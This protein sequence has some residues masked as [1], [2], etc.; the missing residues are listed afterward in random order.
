VSGAGLEA[1]FIDSAGVRLI[2]GLYLAGG[3]RP[4]PA[5]LLLHG[6]PGH[7][8]NLDLAV[9]LRQTGLHCLYF[10]YRGAW[11]SPGRFSCASLVADAA[12]ALDWL[13]RR[14]EVD[15]RRIVLVGF[16]LGGWVACTLAADCAPA[17]LVAV[18]PLV[19]PRLV[20]LPAALA[21][22]SAATLNGTT[23]AQLAAEWGSLPPL[24]EVA[25]RLQVLKFLLVT[26]DQDSLFPPSHFDSFVAD[27]PNLKRVQFP[28][29]EHLFSEVRPGLRHVICR[30]LAETLEPA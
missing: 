24:T 3:T 9:E 2:G 28:Q 15:P 10:H 5:A 11:G 12:A 27:L 18:A 4:R 29:A 21:D 7:E 30:W 23:A 26:G 8:K 14:P 1:A 25:P 6:R 13:A 20:P 19:D 16:S 17:A 22:E